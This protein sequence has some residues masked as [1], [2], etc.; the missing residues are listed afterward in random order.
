[1]AIIV[2]QLNFS[3]EKIQ[4]TMK[5]E[6]HSVLTGALDMMLVSKFI[7]DIGIDKTISPLRPI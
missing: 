7:P 1:M 2:R 5:H 4:V 3:N 6:H